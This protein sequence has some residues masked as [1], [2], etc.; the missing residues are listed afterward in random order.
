MEKPSVSYVCG[1][2]ADTG[3]S[4]LWTHHQPPV[5]LPPTSTNHTKNANQPP[6]TKHHH[7]SQHRW[8]PQFRQGFPP[9]VLQM[10][11][12]R[13]QIG[14][15]RI[16]DPLHQIPHARVQWP[17]NVAEREVIKTTT[18]DAGANSCGSSQR[19]AK[20]QV[21]SARFATPQHFWSS[22]GVQLGY[23]GSCGSVDAHEAN[24]TPRPH[25]CSVRP[26]TVEVSCNYG[27]VD[28]IMMEIN[29]V[30]IGWFGRIP[31]D[32]YQP[33][34]LSTYPS[35]L[36]IYLSV[37]FSAPLHLLHHSKMAEQW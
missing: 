2:K 16:W 23:V 1:A 5:P 31:I 6:P 13:Q 17:R 22:W 14:L 8:N 32:R 37:Y 19:T 27:W 18:R 21:S 36:S 34:Y 25:C 35:I 4:Y 15:G 33:T 11:A 24:I 10:P 7:V 20:S 26:F 29:M 28:H 3:W 30:G 12:G 9:A